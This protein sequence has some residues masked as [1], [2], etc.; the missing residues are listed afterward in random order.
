M[1]Q[2][3]GETAARYAVRMTM[4]F[5]ACVTVLW[6]L[7]LLDHHVFG[8]ERASLIK[9]QVGLAAL[10]ALSVWLEGFLLFGLL[11]GV[12]WER[13]HRRWGRMFALALGLAAS[14]PISLVL[15][16]HI[17]NGTWSDYSAPLMTSFLGGVFS[18]LCGITVGVRHHRDTAYR[19]EWARV[20][21]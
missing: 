15:L 10:T 12:E 21:A 7:I 16:M 1:A 13:P 8:T 3:T 9:I 11:A 14:W 4:R 5:T 17:A 19:R 18:V 6:G 2:K 20:A